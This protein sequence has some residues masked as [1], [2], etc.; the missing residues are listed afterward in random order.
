MFTCLFNE[1]NE[2]VM[3]LFIYIILPPTTITI[4]II[5]I[6]ITTIIIGRPQATITKVKVFF[7]SGFYHSV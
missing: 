4:T 5:T 2:K 1:L 6:I 3:T 7:F